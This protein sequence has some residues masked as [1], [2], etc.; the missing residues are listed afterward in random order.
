MKNDELGCSI[1]IGLW[2]HDVD[3][4]A[5]TP[6]WDFGLSDWRIKVVVLLRD[7]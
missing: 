2:L 3:T 4:R 7:I 1:D 6:T 5:N